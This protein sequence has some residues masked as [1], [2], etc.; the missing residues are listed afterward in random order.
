[1]SEVHLHVRLYETAAHRQALDKDGK[2]A[3]ERW[4]RTQRAYELYKSLGFTKL[5]GPTRLYP[6]DSATQEYMSVSTTVLKERLKNL[7]SETDLPRGGATFVVQPQCRL[8]GK[9][10]RWFELEAIDAIAFEHDLANGGDGADVKDVLPR[11]T[12]KF[13]LFSLVPTRAPALPAAPEVAREM[14]GD[15]LLAEDMGEMFNYQHEVRVDGNG[16]VGRV[17]LD[18][19]GQREDQQVI[20]DGVEQQTACSGGDTVDES[21][22]ATA[23]H[24]VM[25]YLLLERLRGCVILPGGISVDGKRSVSKSAYVGYKMTYDA[26]VVR[27]AQRGRKKWTTVILQ[28]LSSGIANKHWGRD[29]VIGMLEKAQ[30]ANKFAKVRV[31]NGSDGRANFVAHVLPLIDQLLE[32]QEKGMAI[33]ELIMQLPPCMITLGTQE[34]ASV[35]VN[36]K[37]QVFLNNGQKSCIGMQ[38]RGE[39]ASWEDCDLLGREAEEAIITAAV[40]YPKLCICLDGGAWAAAAGERCCAERPSL[41]TSWT[42]EEFA[43]ALEWIW[44]EEG[45]TVYSYCDRERPSDPAYRTLAVWAQQWRKHGTG[46]LSSMTRAVE[47]VPLGVVED[48]DAG[49]EDAA[50]QLDPFEINDR[51]RDAVKTRNTDIAKGVTKGAQGEAVTTWAS[52]RL[53]AISPKTGQLAW[54][55]DYESRVDGER[56]GPDMLRYGIDTPVTEPTLVRMP[57]KPDPSGSRNLPNAAWGDRRVMDYACLC[58]LH[59]AMRTGENLYTRV[60]AVR[61]A[62]EARKNGI[63]AAAAETHILGIL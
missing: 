34:N 45:E 61:S 49:D 32:L 27:R 29:A 10:R 19:D 11:G 26:A 51:Q 23:A 12:D 46:K 38:W 21:W 24:E 2:P 8:T 50:R 25:K 7:C 4:E 47:R 48:L 5:C 35:P 16:N 17:Y 15:I 3:P 1:V 54:L 33:D 44:L 57:V 20:T 52:A 43:Q 6:E 59:C 56:R 53:R 18:A 39:K 30:S 41:F 62:K 36:M 28:V 31:W 22:G 40:M 55:S 37:H 13:S 58:I 63:L 14:V 9:G 42:K 60:L